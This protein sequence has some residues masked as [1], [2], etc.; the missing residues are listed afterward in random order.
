[1]HIT[2]KRYFHYRK[3]LGMTPVQAWR[4]AMHIVP[5]QR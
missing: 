2:I 3:H 1:M 4:L 5:A